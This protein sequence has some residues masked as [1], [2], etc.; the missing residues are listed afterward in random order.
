MTILVG[1]QSQVYLAKKARKCAPIMTSPT[2]NPK[3]ETQTFFKLNRR[4][5]EFVQ[6]SNSSLAQFVGELW[7]CK[8]AEHLTRKIA[9]A[10]LGGTV[11]CV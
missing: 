10:G 9:R 11:I 1:P 2:E 6:G 4:L 8:V 3:P 5:P 7:S